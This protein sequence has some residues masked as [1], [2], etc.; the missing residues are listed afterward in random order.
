VKDAPHCTRSPSNRRVIE[1]PICVHG[2]DQDAGDIPPQTTRDDPIWTNEEGGPA[3]FPRGGI[4]AANPDKVIC[5]FSLHGCRH[6]DPRYRGARIEFL[7]FGSYIVT[8]RCKILWRDLSGMERV[9]HYLDASAFVFPVQ[10]W[11]AIIVADQ[12]TA[13][14]AFDGEQG[15]VVTRAI[16]GEVARLARSVPGAKHFVV[17]IYELTLVVNDVEAVVR[18]VRAGQRV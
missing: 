8:H 7:E 3:A 12:R 1:T 4:R 10:F 13:S 15:K 11:I 9:E 17:A 5:G 18:F 2:R 6:R 16:M 14:N